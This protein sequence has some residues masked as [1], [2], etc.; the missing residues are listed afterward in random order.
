MDKITIIR[1]AGGLLIGGGIGAL[2]GYFGSCTSGTCPLTANPFRGALYGAVMGLLFAFSMGCKKP[3]EVQAFAEEPAP[4]EKTHA[5]IHVTSGEQLQ[6]L[7]SSTDKPVLAD[8][9]SMTCPPCRMLAPVIE[10]LANDYDGRAVVCKVSLDHARELGQQFQIRGIPAVLIFQNG[11]E[12]NR[13]VGFRSK[14]AYSG[15]LDKLITE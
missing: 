15:I 8:F 5:A 6:S 10:E 7:L 12:V 4:Q 2:M 14:D 9:Y 1:I 11:Q 13:L 3:E